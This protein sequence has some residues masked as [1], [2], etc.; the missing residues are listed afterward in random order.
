[1]I[2]WKIL[3]MNYV[4]LRTTHYDCVLNGYYGWFSVSKNGWGSAF[5][6]Y[7]ILTSLFK[8]NSYPYVWETFSPDYKGQWQVYWT[9]KLIPRLIC[10]WSFKILFTLRRK[11]RNLNCFF[12]SNWYQNEIFRKSQKLSVYSPNLFFT[13]LFFTKNIKIILQMNILMSWKSIKFTKRALK[14]LILNTRNY[15]LWH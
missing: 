1:M 7:S 11:P 14:K 15:F 10:L 2:L 4:M 5:P 9:W 12:H 13:S 3:G 8:W 6:F